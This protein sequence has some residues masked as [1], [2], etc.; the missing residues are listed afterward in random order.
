[1]SGGWGSILVIL[2]SIH[3]IDQR[4]P[5]GKQLRRSVHCVQCV[6]CDDVCFPEEKREELPFSFSLP[7]NLSLSLNGTSSDH[8]GDTGYP[9]DLGS[10]KWCGL[11]DRGDWLAL[12][13]VVLPFLEVDW[14]EVENSASSPYGLNSALFHG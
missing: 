4:L 10:V 8:S 11:W 1:M 2:S 5:Q 6:Q 14:G 7:A 9:C 13:D 12:R 3:D